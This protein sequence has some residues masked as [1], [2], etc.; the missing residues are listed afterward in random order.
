MSLKESFN[1]L[2]A[3]RDGPHLLTITESG[4]Y[5]N[6]IHTT[7]DFAQRVMFTHNTRLDGGTNATP[8][9]QLDR[10]VLEAARDRL[11]DLGGDPPGLPSDGPA[12]LDKKFRL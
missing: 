5:L 12:A 2:Y 9:S 8:F 4:S 6:E 11:V 10:E 1:R 7:Y 3:R